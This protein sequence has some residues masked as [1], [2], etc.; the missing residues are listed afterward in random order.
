MNKELDDKSL[1]RIHAQRIVG[2]DIDQLLGICE[3]ALQ[4]GMIDQSEAESILA[5][6]NNHQE[7][8]DTWPANILYDRLCIMLADGVLDNSEQS[9]LLGLILRIAQPRTGDAQVVPSA[10]PLDK[11]APQIVFENRNFCFTGVF[12]FGSRADCQAAVSDMGG[13]SLAG[14]TKKLH[15][16]VIGNIGSEVWRYSSFGH[17]IM[18]AVEYRDSGLPIAIISENHW[19]EHLK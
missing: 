5:W 3:F 19:R 13:I 14:I 10:L 2:R 17:K 6:L 16:L 15:Y 9:E 11:P 7:C 8:L 18:K 12:D 4:D 1:L